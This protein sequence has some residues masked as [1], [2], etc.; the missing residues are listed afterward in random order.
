MAAVVGFL[1]A[2]GIVFES[3]E[4]YRGFIVVAGTL[5][6]VAHLSGANGGSGAVRCRAAAHC[7]VRSG[8]DS[9]P[10]HRPPRQCHYLS[11][12]CFSHAPG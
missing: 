8:I 5:S 10:P 11:R 4:P 6:G 7:V 3:A 9:G 12:N 1:G 2:V